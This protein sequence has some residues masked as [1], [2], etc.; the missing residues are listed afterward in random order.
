MRLGIRF[1]LSSNRRA[2]VVVYDISGTFIKTVTDQEHIAGWNQVFWD[3]KN[4]N[5][6][7]VGNGVYVAVLTSGSFKQVRKFILVR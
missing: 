6:K 5:Q 1:K 7:N 2:K 3:G 4:F